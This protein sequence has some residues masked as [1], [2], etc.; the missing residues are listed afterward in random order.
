M[1]DVEADE[2]F[3][4]YFTVEMGVK[5]GVKDVEAGLEAADPI[6]CECSLRGSVRQVGRVGRRVRTGDFELDVMYI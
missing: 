6:V 3:S 2:C 5:L 1:L 4:S